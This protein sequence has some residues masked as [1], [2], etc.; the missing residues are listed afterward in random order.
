MPGWM[1]LAPALL[2]VCA[3]V[4][5]WV[6]LIVSVGADRTAIEANVAEL[7]A[8]QSEQKASSLAGATPEKIES[9]DARIRQ[10]RKQTGQL[11]VAL[12][13]AWGQT[14]LLGGLSI[15]VAALAL[16]AWWLALRARSVANTAN[17]AR[18]RFLAD[19][20]HE[21]RVPLNGVIGIAQALRAS[22]LDAAQLEQL[23]VIHYSGETA[24]RL[25]NDLLDLA[26]LE[27]E[28]LTLEAE[29][30]RPAELA[31]HVVALGRG[32]AANKGLELA[33]VIDA[34]VPAALIG[35]SFRLQQIL[36]NLISNAL[37]F[38][39]GGRVE[40]ALSWEAEHLVARVTDTGVGMSPAELATV[41]D[42][43][44]QASP[45]VARR[46]GGT[47]L[48][49]AIVKQLVE[50]MGGQVVATSTAGAGT[51]LEMR[52]P[53]RR[54]EVVPEPAAETEW[55]ERV[56]RGSAESWSRTTRLSIAWSRGRF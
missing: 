39:A 31:R 55:L 48:G 12:G 4:A 29:P 10:I 40:L 32:V 21:L 2:L 37:K 34:D 46:Y 18:M 23:R 54:S 47:G 38:T 52:V 25:L 6:T 56:Q 53:A 3:F 50:R 27:A 51:C 22:E 45:K 28:A 16:L 1:R 26:K 30:F 33:L 13:D 19:V 11:S 35:D 7:R 5:W 14:Y 24:L 9:L 8:L 42:A 17:D 44:R 15:L 36:N 49:L 20:S 41:F 43:F